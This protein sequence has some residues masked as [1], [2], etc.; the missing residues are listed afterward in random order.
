MI[1]LHWLE[2]W[3]RRWR[4]RRP[5]LHAARKWRVLLALPAPLRQAVR[6]PEPGASLRTRAPLGARGAPPSRR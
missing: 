2:T 3:L 6:A 4:P 1:A 5:T